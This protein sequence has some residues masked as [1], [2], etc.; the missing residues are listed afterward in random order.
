MSMFMHEDHY[1]DGS[2]MV[3]S[4]MTLISYQ[5]MVNPLESKFNS[6]CHMYY[7]FA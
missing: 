6:E 3:Y 5:S 1:R 7:T 4:W 2:W